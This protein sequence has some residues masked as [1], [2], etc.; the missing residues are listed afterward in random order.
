MR[1]VGR[2]QGFYSSSS[3]ARAIAIVASYDV[4][5]SHHHQDNKKRTA[6]IKQ[7]SAENLYLRFAYFLRRINASPPSPKRL[8]VA[9]SGM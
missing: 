1:G 3:A 6:T 4:T 7:L 8:I 2:W 9:G 5:V